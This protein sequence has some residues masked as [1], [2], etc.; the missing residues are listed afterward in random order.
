MDPVRL[1]RG[2]HVYMS[3]CVDERSQELMNVLDL[4]LQQGVR[5]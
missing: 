1:S 3:V 4:F 5:R 2:E